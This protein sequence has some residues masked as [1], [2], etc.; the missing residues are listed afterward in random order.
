VLAISGKGP[1]APFVA[2]A[3][4]AVVPSYVESATVVAWQPV[5]FG[6]VAVVVA[7][8]STGRLS[9]PRAAIRVAA[10]RSTERAGRSPVSARRVRA[11]HGAEGTA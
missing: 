11:N 3:L 4:L 6:V 10:E 8:A 2:A 5:A 1:T 7:L 9:S